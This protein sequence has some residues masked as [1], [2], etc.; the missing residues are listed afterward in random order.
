MTLDS[1]NIIGLAPEQLSIDERRAL[2]GQ[3]IAL[4]LYSP[5]TLP[6]RRIEALGS[7]VTECVRQL[8][9]RGLDPQRFEFVVMTP[10]YR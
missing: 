7:S 5:A 3:W 4:E 2:A 8:K 1:A 6:Q 10:P 9:Q